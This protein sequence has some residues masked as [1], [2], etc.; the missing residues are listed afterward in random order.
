M[1]KLNIISVVAIVSLASVIVWLW[2]EI[3]NIPQ[4]LEL[5]GPSAEGMLIENVRVI[6][7]VPGAPEVEEGRAV[8]I[9][10]DR[11]VKIGASGGIKTPQGV[12]VIDGQ[13]QTL[14][15][16]LI[17]AHMHLSDEAELAAYLSHGV[18]GLRNMSGY[19]FHLQLAENIR[20]GVILGPDFIT[21]GPILNSHG[22]NENAVQQIVMTDV[23]ARLAVQAQH[24]AGYRILKVYS[25]L[26]R[27]AFGAILDEA[28]VSRWRVRL[29]R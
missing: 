1:R 21:T 17:D 16:G 23:E 4:A 10:G 18:T 25:N 27:E 28:P 5:N 6:S 26:T 11:I 3:S 13:G 29:S 20:A 12:K 14:I 2:Y 7:M 24:D 15:P 22:P 9:K 8:L 19:P